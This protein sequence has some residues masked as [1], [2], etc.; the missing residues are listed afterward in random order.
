MIDGSD[1]DNPNDDKYIELTTSNSELPNQV[2]NA[3]ATD[4]DGEVLGGY[5]TRYLCV[6]LCGQH[7]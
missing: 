5:Y 1:I 6:P 3:L 4:L 2:I 7:V